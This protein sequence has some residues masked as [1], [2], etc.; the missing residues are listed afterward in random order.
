MV[1]VLIESDCYLLCVVP[2]M[3]SLKILS[4]AISATATYTVRFSPCDNRYLLGCGNAL[5]WVFRIR[6]S[7]RWLSSRTGGQ[8]SYREG[9]LWLYDQSLS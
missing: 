2:M 4:A 9:L 1:R 3:S 5:V 8:S 6:W 7:A